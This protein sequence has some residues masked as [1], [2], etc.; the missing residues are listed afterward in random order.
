MGG[1]GARARRGDVTDRARR[2]TSIADATRDF[3]DVHPSV[4]EGLAE[5]IVNFTA[6]AR[7][8]QA[9]L[10]LPNE[11]AVT[12]ACRRYQRGLL[13]GRESERSIDRILGA[14]RLLV[15]SRV[16]LVRVRDDWE[17]ID[18]LL[19]VGR[20]ALPGR[21]RRRLFQIFQGTD[22]ITILCEEGFLSTLLPEIPARLRV[23]V[24][25]GLGFIAFRS[26]PEVA[27]TP[28]VVARMSGALHRRGI[29]SLET[30]SVHTD[31]IFVFRDRDMIRAY[32]VL[33]A[34]AGGPA[35]APS[36]GEQTELS[37]A[38]DGTPR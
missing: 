34:L 29:N 32:Q 23:A 5:D 16:A 6:L 3:L 26:A 36:R 37:G 38:P 30:V 13:Q 9:E 35:G 2:T 24:E 7:R 28:G 15:Q 25:R 4:R 14:S 17:L 8:I 1:H 27:E 18:R 12:I 20:A 22:A 11:E 33:S 19:E 10:E 21:G 31:S